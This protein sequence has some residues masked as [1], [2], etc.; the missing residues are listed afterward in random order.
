MAKQVCNELSTTDKWVLGLSFLGAAIYTGV[1]LHQMGY[2]KRLPDPPGF[3]SNELMLTETAYPYGIPDGLLA[4]GSMLANIPL[5]LNT[6]KT[7]V[8]ALSAAK[9]VTE[10]GIAAWFL[11]QMR[12]KYKV[13]CIYC[14][15]AGGIYF[16]LAGLSVKRLLGSHRH[17]C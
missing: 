14:I 1:A 17:T 3:S 7:G 12:F 15:T 10:A 11:Y 5:A 6:E 13:W 9:S 2:I 8:A 4:T 16:S